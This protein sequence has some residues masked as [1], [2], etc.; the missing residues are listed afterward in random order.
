M[1]SSE[2]KRGFYKK[3]LFLS[4]LYVYLI[5]LNIVIFLIVLIIYFVKGKEYK[6]FNVISRGE[7]F[8]FILTLIYGFYHADRKRICPICNNPM[9]KT[10][11]NGN[12]YY[13]CEKDNI[14]VNTYMD[15]NT[16]G[17]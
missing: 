5:A 6:Y 10:I 1:K 3:E 16:G 11:E 7:L 14:K 17:G 12:L 9:L 2:K 4:K 15:V 8:F 13:K